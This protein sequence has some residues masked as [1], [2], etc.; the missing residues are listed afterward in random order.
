MNPQLSQLVVKPVGDQSQAQPA[1]N[2]AS[3]P[4][5]KPEARYWKLRTVLE[6]LKFGFS[7]TWEMI[8]NR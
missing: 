7:I 2:A 8:K 3:P 1:V 5:D 6:V 4:E